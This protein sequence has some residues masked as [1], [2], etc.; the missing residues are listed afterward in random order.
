MA[1][2]R[3]R[4]PLNVRQWAC[5]GCGTVH[6]RDLNAAKNI[7]ALG[8][9]ERLNACGDGVSLLLAGGLPVKQEPS[10]VP[11]ERHGRNPRAFGRG[12]RQ[13]DSSAARSRTANR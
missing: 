8:R 13:L 10:E 5:A 11:R 6:D 12:G 7:L 4:R 2:G 1:R 9:R 3:V